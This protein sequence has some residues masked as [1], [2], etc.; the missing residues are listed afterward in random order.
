MRLESKEAWDMTG[1]SN[2]VGACHAA[3]IE[4]KVAS[5]EWD[6]LD[7]DEKLA[8]SGVNQM[9][10]LLGVK[11]T[12]IN[13]GRSADMQECPGCKI[14]MANMKCRECGIDWSDSVYDPAVQ[15]RQEQQENIRVGMRSIANDI[16]AR[17][18]AGTK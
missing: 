15:A 7:T 17:A 6:S 11:P 9:M 3:G 4:G 14:P 13:Y 16:V 1:V 5:R 10:A 8:L 18:L 12:V 2:R